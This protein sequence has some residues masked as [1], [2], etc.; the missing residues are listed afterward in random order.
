MEKVTLYVKRIL[1][2]LF[3]FSLTAFLVM[4]FGQ[5]EALLLLPGLPV[6]F[7]LFSVLNFKITGDKPMYLYGITQSDAHLTKKGGFWNLFKWIVNVLGFIYDL[8]LWI[9]WGAFLLF[10]LIVDLIMLI[11]FVVYWIIHAIIWFIRQLFPPFIFIFRIFIHY[12]INW[13]WWIYQLAFRNMR[14]SVNK[15]F[16]IIALWGAIPALF[17][18]FLFFAVSQLVD[19]P[20]LVAIGAIFAIVPLVW[21]FG[22]IAALRYEEREKDDY[23]TVK[24]RFRN[25][26]DSVRS[27]LF[28]L[29]AAVILIIAERLLN[30]VGWIPNLSL[31]FIGIALNLNMLFSLILVFLAVIISFGG[32]MLP[33]HILYRPEHENDLKSSLGFLKVIG[34]KFLRY[35][36]VHLPVSVFGGLL[37]II[38]VFVIVLTYSLTQNIKNSVMDTKIIDLQEKV[39]SMDPVDAHRTAIKIDRLEMYKNLPLSAPDYFGDLNESGDNIKAFEKGLDNSQSMLLDKRSQHSSWMDEMDAALVVAKADTINTAQFSELTAERQ[40]MQEEYDEWAA[41]NQVLTETLQLDLK[42]QRN[43]R[44]QMPILYFF[45]GILLAVFGGLIL[46]VFIAY[47]GNVA[48]ELYDMREDGKPT[49]WRATINDLKAKNGNQ[50]LLGFTFLAIIAALVWLLGFGGVDFLM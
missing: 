15:N 4:A 20:L 16:Y 23:N 45:V 25:G 29:L 37:L 36:F 1:A 34:Q 33:S 24:S 50:P 11:K 41:D 14:I 38:P 32:L 42:E 17:I 8:L 27:V 39:I 30:L 49:Y 28:Y 22:E 35:L 43:L 10:M 44:I 26:W 47:I 31:S 48:F 6:S 12:I 9:F 13:F 3:S 40:R 19:T 5:N 7:L 21:S 18:V 2:L 46:A